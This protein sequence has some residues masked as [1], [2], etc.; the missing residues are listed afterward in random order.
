MPEAFEITSESGPGRAVRIRVAGRLD[1]KSAPQ[2]INR[3]RAERPPGGHLVLNLE[4][5]TFLSS[6][7][8]GALLVL[9]EQCREDDGSMRLAA[10]SVAVRSALGLLNLDRFLHL[11]ASEQDALAAIEAA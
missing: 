5:V 11:D 2:L 10:A 7:G 9:A 1:A 3:C 8:V 4:R 6:S